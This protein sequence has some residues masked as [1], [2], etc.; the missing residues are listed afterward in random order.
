MNEMLIAPSVLTADFMNMEAQIAMLERSGA[1]MI[2]LDVMDGM[3]VP[4][5]TFGPKFISDMRR[6]TDLPFDIHLMIQKP[7]RYIEK[8]ATAGEDYVSIHY[9]ATENPRNCLRAIRTLGA[10]ACIAINPETPAEKVLDLLDVAD[11]VLVMSVHPGFGGQSF[12]PE[13]LDK[14][15]FLSEKIKA[16]KPE[17]RL[18]VDGG[19][20][21]VNIAAV[22]RAGA[23]T[24]VAGSAVVSAPDPAEAIRSLKAK[25]STAVSGEQA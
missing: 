12:L 24:I 13:A 9:E 23:D 22:A 15:R 7:E 25:W 14:L 21:K 1:D 16:F 4:N 20:N 2:H 18:E 6:I 3:F 8:F 17:I 11:M 5:I 10:G 19:V